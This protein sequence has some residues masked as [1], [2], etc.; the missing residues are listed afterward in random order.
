MK[1]WI[2]YHVSTNLVDQ[3]RRVEK[4]FHDET[5]ALLWAE[6]PGF[7]QAAKTWNGE[8]MEWRECEEREVE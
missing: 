7:A 1:V 8:V 5:K 4:V 6:D 2:G 3:W